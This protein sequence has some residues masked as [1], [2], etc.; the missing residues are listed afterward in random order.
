MLSSTSSFHSLSSTWSSSE[1]DLESKSLFF[2]EDLP[3]IKSH[4][5][6][7]TLVP[8]SQAMAEI[9]K[10]ANKNGKNN[11]TNFDDSEDDERGE[12]GELRLAL[13]VMAPKF[14]WIKG[15]FI[16]V[17]LSLFGVY[18][19]LRFPYVVAQA[20]VGLSLVILV[21]GLAVALATTLSIHLMLSNGKVKGGGCYA[22]SSRL[23]GPAFGA[24]VGV[25]FS[26]SLVLAMTSKVMGFAEAVVSAEESKYF[27]ILGPGHHVWELR[28]WGIIGLTCIILLVFI[29][30]DVVIKNDAFQLVVLVVCLAVL[31]AGA[32]TS[33]DNEAK[34][35]Q[36]A[37][38]ALLKENWGPKYEDTSVHKPFFYELLLVFPALRG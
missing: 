20:G 14:G 13:V 25:L 5:D 9:S 6:G 24:V 31:F 16:R 37:N 7:S 2:N 11:I 22:L 18:P 33:D 17:I 8:V 35:F 29:G 1:D 36:R 21:I 4:L 10:K 26:F 38:M 15:V 32:F 23:M 19:W 3:N 27:A 28:I 12:D 34:G 30:L